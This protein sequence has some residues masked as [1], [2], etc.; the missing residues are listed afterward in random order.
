MAITGTT[1]TAA[2]ADDDDDICAK[3]YHQ[4]GFDEER[5]EFIENSC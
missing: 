1:M 3:N 5:P 2:A 4:K